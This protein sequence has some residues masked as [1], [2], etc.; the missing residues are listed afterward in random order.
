MWTWTKKPLQT[1]CQ[2]QT[3]LYQREREQKATIHLN[4]SPILNREFVGVCT[5]WH[6]GHLTWFCFMNLSPQTNLWIR[7]SSNWPSSLWWKLFKFFWFFFWLDTCFLL[8]DLF[9][10]VYHAA[11]NHI[12]CV[13]LALAL[14]IWPV[15]RLVCNHSSEAALHPLDDDPL[16][17]IYPALSP[18]HSLLL[19]CCQ[20]YRPS[21]S[22]S[23]CCE[24]ATY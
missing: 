11:F 10:F 23:Q 9:G 15:L 20:Y 4:L 16:H 17:L 14:S 22:T 24:I 13:F 7:T 19:I 3:F 12:L 1:K 6:T 21:N 18:W 2:K 8:F 5:V